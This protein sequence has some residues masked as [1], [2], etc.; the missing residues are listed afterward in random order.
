[1]EFNKESFLEGKI[2]LIYKPL[3]WTS[4]QVVNKIRWLI[5][6][7]FN[8]KKIKVGHAGTLD[9]LADGLLII[10][11]GKMTKKIDQ[12][13]KLNKTYTGKFFLGATTPSYDLETEVNSKK[14]IDHITEKLILKTIES[15][16]G[17]TIQTPPI[18]SAIKHKGKKLYE[19]ARKGE[20]VKIKERE[21]LISEFLITKKQL[22]ELDFI[23][24]CSKGTYIRSLANDFG[25]KLECGAYLSKLTRTAIGDHLLKDSISIED[26]EKTLS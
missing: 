21:I 14:S 5:K 11:T 6:T 12:F 8:I 24:N 13:Q 3:N 9:P 18:Y 22:P 16:K 25:S 17:K 10:C 2:L 23:V 1:M 26:F 20:T 19:F 7:T 15:F 4:F